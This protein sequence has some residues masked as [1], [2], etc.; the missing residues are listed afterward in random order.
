MGFSRG[1]QSSF[2]S[3]QEENEVTCTGSPHLGMQSSS[4]ARAVAI[5]RR[6]HVRFLRGVKWFILEQAFLVFWKNLMNL[7]TD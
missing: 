6:L 3:F 4:E 2:Y 1:K 7:L 5:E